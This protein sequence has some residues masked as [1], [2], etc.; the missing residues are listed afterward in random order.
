[1]DNGFGSGPISS[2]IVNAG[3]ISQHADVLGGDKSVSQAAMAYL[4]D[5]AA[6]PRL[7]T[8]TSGLN[9]C[10]GSILR[11]NPD[12]QRPGGLLVPAWHSRALQEQAWTMLDAGVDM[13]GARL[14]NP[15]T[16]KRDVADIGSSI[17]AH[18]DRGFL[19][20]E[21]LTAEPQH[22]GAGQLPSAPSLAADWA[23]A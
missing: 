22:Q 5:P 3:P 11:A 1:V 18:A 20:W 14:S 8:L 2:C 19:R 15:F 17:L 4:G 21:R 13:I 12:H 9:T 6:Q 16:A 7:I 23:S 10:A